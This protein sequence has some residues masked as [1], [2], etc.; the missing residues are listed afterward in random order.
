MPLLAP[1]FHRRDGLLPLFPPESQGPDNQV[2][3][4]ASSGSVYSDVALFQLPLHDDILKRVQSVI[5]HFHQTF[6]FI[7]VQLF[8]Y[9]VPALPGYY[10]FLALPVAGAAGGESQR[11]DESY[12]AD[13]FDCPHCY[14][15]LWVGINLYLFD[16]N[17]DNMQKRVVCGGVCA[18]LLLA[19][20]LFAVLGMQSLVDGVI[21]DGVVLSP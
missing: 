17:R 3:H 6:R 4:S 2:A 19:L 5:F 9:H 7:S 14:Y 10:V 1:P 8:L 16:N 11:P 20:G 12:K 18:G 21:L 15:Y 13:S